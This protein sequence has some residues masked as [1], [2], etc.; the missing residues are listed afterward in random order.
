MGCPTVVS[1]FTPQKIYR[2]FAAELKIACDAVGLD[3]FVVEA[4]DRGSWLA[5]CARKGTFCLE[6]MHLLER[7]ILWIDADGKPKQMPDLLIDTDKDFAIHAFNG[8]RR[9]PMPNRGIRELPKAW[10]DPPR[11]FNSGTAFFN[12]TSGALTLL[13]RWAELSVARPWDWDQWLLQ[14]AWC[15]LKPSTE[16]LPKSYC[17][18]GGRGPDPVIVHDLASTMQ[19]GIK[20]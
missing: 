5:N 10:D 17:A 6:M 11:W 12:N 8:P 16:W 4:E 20:R 9:R 14:E 19:R 7:P 3:H 15:E 2:D 13:E 1:F 18:I